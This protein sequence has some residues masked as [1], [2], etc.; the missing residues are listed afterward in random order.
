MRVRTLALVALLALTASCSLFQSSEEGAADDLNEFANA[1]SEA[2]FVVSYQFRISGP[3]AEGRTTR[4]QIVQKPPISIRKI[5]IVTND[6][7]GKPTTT[8]SW[9]ARTEKG[10]YSCTDYTVG[11]RCLSDPLASGT[12]GNAVLDEF[13]DTPRKDA[14]YSSVVKTPRSVRIAGEVG[15]CFEAVPV[16][17]T[18]P[19]ITS[20]QPKFTPERFRFDLCYSDDGILLRGRRTI[21]G[22]VPEN[23]DERKEA[24]VEALT[25]S[26]VVQDQELR[27]PGPVAGSQDVRP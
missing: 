27:L 23:V 3:L 1:G 6:S 9:L 10:N 26:R 19:P 24:T 14:V 21:Q 20:P 2:A 25:V 18:A 22:E 8:R 15:T 16:A 11:V 5:E 17:P 4:I 7:K 12:F 13:F